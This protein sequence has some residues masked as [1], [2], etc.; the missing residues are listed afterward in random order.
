MLFQFRTSG[1]VQIINLSHVEKAEYE[2]RNASEAEVTLYMA[3][4]ETWGYDGEI[5]RG[6]VTALEQMKPQSLPRR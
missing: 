6:I 2:D 4:G 3:S 1:K 5:G